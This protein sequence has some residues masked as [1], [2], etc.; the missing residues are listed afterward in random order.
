MRLPQLGGTQTHAAKHRDHDPRPLASRAI[1]SAPGT[2]P[3]PPRHTGRRPRASPSPQE[4]TASTDS[5]P[6]PTAQPRQFFNA[7]NTLERKHLGEFLHEL[8]ALQGPL[9]GP[10]KPAELVK[11]TTASTVGE[12]MKVQFEGAHCSP[13]QGSAG[14]PARQA[15]LCVTPV[16]PPL[17]CCLP[18]CRRWR[19]TAS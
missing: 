10:S 19:P 9:A 4:C 17:S 8:A 16:L 18:V 14:W 11:F 13:R 3:L 12:A 6:G 1:P 5:M 15:Q 7:K 2:A